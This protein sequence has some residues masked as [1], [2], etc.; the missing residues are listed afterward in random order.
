[1]DKIEKGSNIDNVVLT[2]VKS[3][4]WNKM[5][6]IENNILTVKPLI[7]LE[8]GTEYYIKLPQYAVEG[9]ESERIF[10]FTTETQPLDSFYRI[11]GEN[12]YETATN[13]AQHI[14]GSGEKD[15]VSVYTDTFIKD[16]KGIKVYVIGGVNI[17]S[18]RTLNKLSNPER[19]WGKN[20]YETNIAVLNRISKD[21]SLNSIYFATGKEFP[22]A[23]SGS[24]LASVTNSPIFLVG[25]NLEEDASEFI[26][27]NKEK[28]N[29]KYIF[30]GERIIPIEAVNKFTD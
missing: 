26:K 24:I 13:I 20:R 4:V 7:N 29:V 14:G 23:L 18:D 28:V 8:Y 21:L 2:D 17:I 15:E 11:S 22:D 27:E 19:I 25:H 16:N 3:R 1:M 10:K 12:R 6:L 30:G 9:M 5:V